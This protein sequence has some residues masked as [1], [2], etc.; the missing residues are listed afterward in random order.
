MNSRNSDNNSGSNNRQNLI[1]NLRNMFNNSD[2]NTANTTANNASRNNTG[3]EDVLTRDVLQAV[4]NRMQNLPS[5][6]RTIIFNSLGGGNTNTTNNE[7]GT[8]NEVIV[9]NSESEQEGEEEGGEE[10]GRYQRRYHYYDEVAESQDELLNPQEED[11]YIDFRTYPIQIDWGE[12]ENE[13]S[14]AYQICEKFGYFGVSI[15]SSLLKL[16]KLK[17]SSQKFLKTIVE[18]YSKLFEKYEKK[19]ETLKQ[20]EEFISNLPKL[21]QI[22]QVIYQRILTKKEITGMKI[23][24][25]LYEHFYD[26]FDHPCYENLKSEFIPTALLFYSSLSDE[27]ITYIYEKINDSMKETS[28][29]LSKILK[30]II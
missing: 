21:N 14:D 17:L 2:S 26:N 24:L 30:I 15:F 16:P 29:I 28:N 8:R 12:V 1:A 7:E 3:T 11:D 18:Y 27:D 5:S 25:D 19:N 10:S 22:K 23:I 20:I 4:W 13:K 9:G 6:Q